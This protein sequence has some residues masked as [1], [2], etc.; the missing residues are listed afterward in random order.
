MVLALGCVG[1]SP[2]EGGFRRTPDRVPTPPHVSGF[3]WNVRTRDVFCGTDRYL[4][5]GD[6][7]VVLFYLFCICI[8][9]V[10]LFLLFCGPP[11]ARP[12]SVRSSTSGSATTSGGPAG[13][14][15]RR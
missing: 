8:L 2:G 5:F 9:F 1:V 4:L 15:P 12:S 6:P 11:G 10:L 13:R 7:G 3:E 14:A